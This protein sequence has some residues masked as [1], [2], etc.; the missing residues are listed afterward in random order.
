MALTTFVV[1]DMSEQLTSSEERLRPFHF[2]VYMTQWPE[3]RNFEVES[4]NRYLL[5]FIK[6]THTYQYPDW[7]HSKATIIYTDV[8]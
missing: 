3:L 2:K 7:S 5:K 4:T 8:V 1:Y 6:S